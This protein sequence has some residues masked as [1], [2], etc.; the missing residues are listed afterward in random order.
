MKVTDLN[1]ILLEFYNN[2]IIGK[3]ILID[4]KWGC[5]KT[6]QIKEFL[7]EHVENCH[8]LSLF[9]LESIDEINSKLYS[10]IHSTKSFLEKGAML[11]SKA[12]SAVPYVGGIGEALEYQMSGKSINPKDTR[13]IIFDDLERLSKKISYIDLL[14]YFN[15]LF[16]SNVKIV[17]CISFNDFTGNQKNRKNEFMQFREKV[18]DYTYTINETDLTIYKSLFHNVSDDI[19][20]YTLDIFK[21]NLRQAQRTQNFISKINDYIKEKSADIQSFNYDEEDIFVAAATMINIVIYN[22][23]DVVLKDSDCLKYYYEDI[24]GSN[25]AKGLYEFFGNNNPFFSNYQSQNLKLLVEAFVFIYMFNEFEHF[26]LLLCNKPD[27]EKIY[28][29]DFFYLSEN[30]KMEYFN[31]VNNYDFK[32]KHINKNI[33]LIFRNIIIHSNYVFDEDFIE[34]L[35]KYHFS[36]N[37]DNEM[38]SHLSEINFFYD[39]SEIP[40]DRKIYVTDIMDKIKNNIKNYQFAYYT[41][42]IKQLYDLKKYN[43]LKDLLYKLENS[44]LEHLTG[45]IIDYVIQNDFF[46]IDLSKDLTYDEWIYCHQMSS[47]IKYAGKEQEFKNYV[48][49]VCKGKNDNTLFSRFAALL[50][51]KCGL[52]LTKGDIV[53]D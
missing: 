45:N 1:R 20:V 13:Y 30:K 19:I 52:E 11:V 2:Q 18:F 17:C 49:S 29:K 7:K 27:V 26:D 22:H 23:E 16:L 38:V 39:Y 50:K 24:F 34:E 4:G 10:E 21:H 32:N 48:I 43:L 15:N 53:T 6:Y 44:Y 31:F 47:F 14:G 28:D 41:E 42:S 37:R 40:N 51:Y 3:A 9:G 5:G 25:V 12:I 36:V 8:Y 46:M 35:S 33:Y